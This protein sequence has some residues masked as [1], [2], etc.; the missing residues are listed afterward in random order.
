MHKACDQSE[1]HDPSCNVGR[2][3]QS[4]SENPH[5]LGGNCDQY[6]SFGN[7]FCK[8]LC[9]QAGVDLSSRTCV[10]ADCILEE[11]DILQLDC[12]DGGCY[13]L[14]MTHPVCDGGDCDQHQAKSPTCAKGGCAQSEAKEPS[15]AGGFCDQSKSVRGNCDP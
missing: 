2:C 13:Q 7:S 10:K 14:G 15:C 3:D 11:D 4:H 12:P 1:A 9:L 5:C 6:K 8:A